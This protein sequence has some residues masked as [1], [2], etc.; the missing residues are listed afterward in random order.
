MK[1]VLPASKTAWLTL[2]AALSAHVLLISLAA[3]H[4]ELTGILRAWLLDALAPIERVVDRTLSSVGNVWDGYLD[5]RRVREDNEELRAQNNRLQLRLMQHSEDLLEVVRLRRALGYAD[6]AALTFVPSRIIGKDATTGRHTLTIDKGSSSGLE[7]ST[8]VV[9]PDGVVG[10]VIEVPSKFAAIVQMLTDTQSAV[11][12]LVGEGRQQGIVKG[13]GGRLLE[14]DYIEDYTD[15]KVN[16]PVVTSGLD[17]MYRKGLPV[18]TI[19]WIGSREEGG[20]LPKVLIQP[21]VDFGR[22]EEVLCVMQ[23]P[24]ASPADIAAEPSLEPAP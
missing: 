21:A 7:L 24:A 12:V 18:G 6:T 17:M 19:I 14:L 8:A 5:L 16:D 13:V 2:A 9:T 4:P 15:L 10:R 23:P 20:L 1:T 22:L 3:T 11:G